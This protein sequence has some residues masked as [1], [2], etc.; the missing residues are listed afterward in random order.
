MKRRRYLRDKFK[1][2]GLRVLWYNAI[3]IQT[4]PQHVKTFEVYLLPLLLHPRAPKS[5]EEE[6]QKHQRLVSRGGSTMTTRKGN[7]KKGAPRH[8][9]RTEFKHNPSSKKTKKILA[10]PNEGLCSRCHE[11][12]EWKKKYRKYKPLT[13][14][15]KWFYSHHHNNFCH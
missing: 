2:D 12:I 1:V 6:N 10:M 5:F 13:T 11:I 14:A 4:P 3:S 7:P 9:N 15:K 8:Q